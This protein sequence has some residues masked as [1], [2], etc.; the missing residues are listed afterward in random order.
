[1][2]GWKRGRRVVK[3]CSLLQGGRFDG[4]QIDVYC[5]RASACSGGGGGSMGWHGSEGRR[6][7]APK[8]GPFA[9]WRGT[10]ACIEM[11]RAGYRVGRKAGDSEGRSRQGDGKT[12]GRFSMAFINSS[13]FRKNSKLLQPALTEPALCKWWWCAARHSK[14]MCLDRK[15]WILVYSCI[16]G[17]L[18]VGWVPLK[19][20][21]G[22]AR[23]DAAR[24]KSLNETKE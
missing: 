20:K 3:A 4:T 17:V 10:R 5:L 12:C 24:A 1:M 11:K 18:G 14:V 6:H 8:T 15:G 13:M 2:G 21:E 19:L 9:R 23:Y 22:P 7:L 16:S